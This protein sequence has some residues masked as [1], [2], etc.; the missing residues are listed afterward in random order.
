[1]TITSIEA[2]TSGSGLTYIGYSLT[3]LIAGGSSTGALDAFLFLPF[4]FLT[5]SFTSTFAC[6]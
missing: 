4:P 1:M 6:S 2:L 3:M 5:F